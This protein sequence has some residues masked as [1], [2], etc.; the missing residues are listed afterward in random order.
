LNPSDSTKSNRP[1]TMSEFEKAIGSSMRRF[2]SAMAATVGS[3]VAVAPGAFAA[4]DHQYEMWT[5]KAEAT[6]STCLK[7]T[8]VGQ[9][10]E[11]WVVT[12]TKATDPDGSKSLLVVAQFDV[13]VTAA[14]PVRK[15]KGSGAARTTVTIDSKLAKAAAKGTVSMLGNCTSTGCTRSPLVVDVKWT[16]VGA[17]TADS[18]DVIQV[19][20]KCRTETSWE[21]SVRGATATGKIGT[22]S[23]V[24]GS[25]LVAPVLS[26]YHEEN[27]VVCR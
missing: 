11:D 18:D 16:G 5:S 22:T 23:F 15:L 14:G 8:P 24:S 6:F 27:G 10:C 4:T 7:T 3:M 21:S 2:I 9:H 13:E 19:A 1:D 12:A 17:V 25:S 20:G 26:I